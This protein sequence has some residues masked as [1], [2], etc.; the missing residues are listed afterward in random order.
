MSKQLTSLVLISLLGLAACSGGGGSGRIITNGGGDSA[1]SS[2]SSGSSGSGSTA[3]SGGA[4]SGSNNAGGVNTQN[5]GNTTTVKKGKYGVV[6]AYNLNP[7]DTDNTSGELSYDAI[8]NLNLFQVDGR[9][10]QLIP[11]DKKGEKVYRNNVPDAKAPYLGSG[12]DP[13][14]KHGSWSWIGND[15]QHAKY[16]ELY[17]QYEKDYIF[18]QGEDTPEKQMPTERKE[19]NYKGQGTHL[20][21]KRELIDVNGSKVPAVVDAA[22]LEAEVDVKVNFGEKTMIGEVRPKDVPAR[23]Q[24]DVRT[25]VLKATIKDNR[26]EG[27][28][29][30]ND[31]KVRGAF[32]GPNAEEMAGTYIRVSPKEHEKWTDENYDTHGVFGVKKQ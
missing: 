18:A 17:D 1:S 16:G 11:D 19:V 7:N 28:E 27:T 12:N 32:Y 30:K 8:D 24:N 26:F 9:S 15:L 6:T 29:N 13:Y 23:I 31:T 3:G 5:G 2:S 4:S 22:F 21:T 25:T 14:R 20:F 10:I